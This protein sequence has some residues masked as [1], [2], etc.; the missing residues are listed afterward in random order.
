MGMCWSCECRTLSNQ[1]T[2]VQ[3]WYVK[4]LDGNTY[5][6]QAASGQYLVAKDDGTVGPGDQPFKW[7]ITGVNNGGS[8]K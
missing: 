6:I 8:W 2:I 1:L 7:D 4:N 5:T 3:D